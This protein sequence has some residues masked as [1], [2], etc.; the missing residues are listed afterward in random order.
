MFIA[1]KPL[2]QRPGRVSADQIVNRLRGKL[3]SVPGAILYLQV[4]QELQSGGRGG[5][6]QYQYTLSDENLDELN[7]WAPQLLARMRGIPELRDVNSDQQNQGLAS[8]LIIDRDTASRLGISAAAIDQVLYDAFGQREVSTMYTALNQYYVV[9]EVD[10]K[11]QLSPDALN[12]IFVK[13]STG[14]MVPLSAIAKFVQQRTALQ[15]N[16]QGQYPAVTLTWRPTWLWATPSQRSKWP[17]A[18]WA[19][20][21]PSTR[22]SREPLRTIRP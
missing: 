20:P 19:C 16:H 14:S 8:N 10:P 9:M 22:H 15:V 11:Y 3:T 7:S 2:D 1:L 13:S 6:A 5:A 18:T 4:Q 12:G 17:S 21:V